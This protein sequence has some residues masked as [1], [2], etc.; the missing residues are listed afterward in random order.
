M[1]KKIDKHMRAIGQRMSVNDLL[2]IRNFAERIKS[3]CLLGRRF[4]EKEPV[5]KHY[6]NG[7][8]TGIYRIPIKDEQV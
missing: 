4:D 8:G 5:L 2:K 7:T 3:V 6:S 1:K